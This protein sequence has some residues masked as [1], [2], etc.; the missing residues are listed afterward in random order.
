VAGLIKVNPR[1]RNC[2]FSSVLAD[3]GTCSTEKRVTRD[4]VETVFAGLPGSTSRT[5]NSRSPAST[6]GAGMCPLTSP[7]S[8][9]GA[10]NFVVSST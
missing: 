1:P 7:L 2:T 9:T 5:V 4:T 6:N 3:F 10:V 8:S